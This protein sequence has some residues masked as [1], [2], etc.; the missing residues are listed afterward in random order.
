MRKTSGGNGGEKAEM[1]ERGKGF[2]RVIESNDHHV[3]GFDPR[4]PT[5]HYPGSAGKVAVMQARYAAGLPLFHPLDAKRRVSESSEDTALSRALI[6]AESGWTNDDFDDDE[7][8]DVYLPVVTARKAVRVGEDAS[9][10]L[11]RMTKRA[12]R[13]EDLHES[14]Q[15]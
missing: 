4:M 8:D 14:E 13:N 2:V 7:D 9:S 12:S 5:N 1:S 6:A 10:L 3:N 15:S 11:R